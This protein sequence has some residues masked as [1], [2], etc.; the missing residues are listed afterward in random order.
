MNNLGHRGEPIMVQVNHQLNRVSYTRVHILN[1]VLAC[2]LAYAPAKLKSIASKKN[3]QIQAW[4]TY[5]KHSMIIEAVAS[6]QCTSWITCPHLQGKQVTP[7]Q[8]TLFKFHN[9]TKVF[10]KHKSSKAMHMS[11]ISNKRNI[12]LFE[13]ELSFQPMR[14]NTHHR[15]CL[16]PYHAAHLVPVPCTYP[17]D[18]L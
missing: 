18:S 14:A 13:L 17:D 8:G 10:M 16:A 11:I 7:E 5:K 9:I 6:I 2:T 1:L 3:C 12:Q 15:S 4:K